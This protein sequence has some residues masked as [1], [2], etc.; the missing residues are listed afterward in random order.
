M[1]P[2]Y[3]K[4]VQLGLKVPITMN[5]M[6]VPFNQRP[7]GTHLWVT[8]I[9]LRENIHCGE[10]WSISVRI[11]RTY[12]R[13]WALGVIGKDPRKQWIAQKVRTESETI[14]CLSQQR[15]SLWGGLTRAGIKLCLV[16]TPQS[17]ISA[18]GS[19]VWKFVVAR[20]VWFALAWTK[21]RSGP[22]LSHFVMVSEWPFLMLVF[23]EIICVPLPHVL[24]HFCSPSSP[25]PCPSL[26][27]HPEESWKLIQRG[28]WLG[29]PY[30]DRGSL[31]PSEGSS[32]NTHKLLSCLLWLPF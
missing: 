9:T 29:L 32:H 23:C 21:V 17:L 3:P 8:S 1:H 19:V 6:S 11:A 27:L 28:R 26:P 31:G 22:V 2:V 4:K 16:K 20:W 10:L 5:R 30:A 12:Y 13:I 25:L 7:P 15:P 14:L 24:S 18:D